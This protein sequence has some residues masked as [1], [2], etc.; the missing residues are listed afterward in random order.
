MLF[1]SARIF[2]LTKPVNFTAET[3]HEQLSEQM[4]VACDS[5]QLSSFG[6]VEPM[7]REGKLLAHQTGRRIMLCACKEERLLPATVLREAV[8]EEVQQIETEQARRVFPSEKRRL[9]E[10]ALQRMLPRAFTKKRLVYGYIDLDNQWLVIEAGP[11]K[12]A[13]EFTHLLRQSLGSLAIVP[14]ITQQEPAAVMSHWLLENSLPANLETGEDCVLRDQSDSKV[15]LRSKGIDLG[16]PDFKVYVEG[17]M[18][19]V[20]LALQW[21]QQL[22]FVIN[23]DLSLSRI[24]FN[25]LSGDGGEVLDSED[26]AGRFDADLA[27]LGGTFEELLNELIE[28]F[29]GIDESI[30]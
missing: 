27:L 26:V 18:R 10:D 19:V 16:S 29:G 24:R 3:L 20:K 25:D 5:Y 1:K 28:A 12:L 30:S 7:G 21:Q 6:W 23:D 13:E 15:V 17:G 22:D 2:R 8:E 14:L 4:F 9:K 11:T